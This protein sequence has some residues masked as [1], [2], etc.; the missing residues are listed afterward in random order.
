MTDTPEQFFAQNYLEARALFLDAAAKAGA[1]VE[2]ALNPRAK[3]PNGHPLHMDRASL[4]PADAPDALVVISGT[5]GPEGYCGSGVQ[6]G[7]LATGLAQDWAKH[8]R[9]ILIHAHNPYGFAWDTRFNED[10]IDLNRNY[11]KSFEAPLPANPHYEQLAQ[12]AAPASRDVETLEEAEKHL[13]GFA[14]QHG[15]AALQAAVTGGQYSHPKGVYFGGHGPSWSNIQLRR[16]LASHCA[17]V[18]RVVSVDMHTGLGPLG[19]GE[20]ITDAAPSSPHHDRLS[21]IWGTQ[22]CSTKDGSSVSADLS[23]TMDSALVAAFGDAWSAC[24]AIEF[25]T[26]EPMSVFRATQAS[27]WLHCYGDPS[28]PEATDIA[29]QSRAA[30]YPNTKAWKQQVW[31]R[32]HDVLTQAVK[33]LMTPAP[34]ASGI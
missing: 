3:G 11:L 9:V 12:W 26:I 27:S 25:G 15:F 7:L 10:N 24:A 32:S 5:H 4:G 14:A 31:T 30:F 33:H 22:V 16:F 20:I 18:T 28:G 1:K 13:F 6:T 23:G 19:H 17:G 21:Q 8:L 29:A 2:S 34:H